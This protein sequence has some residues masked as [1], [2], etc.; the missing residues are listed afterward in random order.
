MLSAV[1]CLLLWAV[2]SAVA[3]A[4]PGSLQ[5]ITVPF[6][7]RVLQRFLADEAAV[8]GTRID[9]PPF[10][11]GGCRWQVSLYPFG[12]NADPS[13]AGRTA[14][15][16][17][18]MP[19]APEGDAQEVD[20]T[21]SLK[22][23]VRPM[24]VEAEDEAKTL[25]RQRGLTFN[26]GM[27]FCPAAEA[28]ES[29]GRCNDWGAHVYASDLLLREL[30]RVPAC[31]PAVEVE[32]CVWEQRPC[33]QG[34]GLMALGDQVRRLPRRSIRVG[35]VIVALADGPQVSDTAGDEAIAEAD[36]VEGGASPHYQPL[37]GV[38]YRVMRITAP[39]GT[40]RFT[41]DLD[42]DGMARPSTVHLLPTSRA[43]RAAG[44]FPSN[45]ALVAR[46]LDGEGDASQLGAGLASGPLDAVTAV[47]GATA[48]QPASWGE[49]TRWPAAVAADR[50]PSLAS[51]LGLRALPARLRYAA[52]TNARMFVLL[53]LLGDRL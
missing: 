43:A 6:P 15:Y 23:L 26:C 45:E 16:L 19:D 9:S 35:E 12:G 44:C 34:A 39:D 17:R 32:L 38:E 1:R 24:G 25:A 14:L 36:G 4:V 3:V 40:A 47:D 30:S 51:R 2:A 29:V 20:A 48:V 49:G 33:R 42:D 8:P 18:H 31:E 53:L 13:F 5:R 50:L 46:L 11:A 22:L 7:R 27:T 10:E 41:A 52:T 21:F 28:G 37:A